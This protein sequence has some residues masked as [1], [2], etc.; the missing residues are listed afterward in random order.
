MDTSSHQTCLTH[1]IY[2]FL[3][4]TMPTVA[5]FLL[6]RTAARELLA[7]LKKAAKHSILNING[8]KAPLKTNQH[9]PVGLLP[10]IPKHFVKL[11]SDKQR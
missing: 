4:F 5:P 9:K 10:L 3:R 6:S 8:W 11:S 2:F 7:R 1:L